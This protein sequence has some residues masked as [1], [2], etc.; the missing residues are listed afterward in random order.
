MDSF[1]MR[2]VTV[3]TI[4]QEANAVSKVGA[5]WVT[6]VPLEEGQATVGATQEEGQATVGATQEEVI[7]TLSHLGITLH[8][9]LPTPPPP[10]MYQRVLLSSSLSYALLH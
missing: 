9:P 6:A 7:M 1:V 4:R 2:I 8:I 3:Q 5:S 10:L